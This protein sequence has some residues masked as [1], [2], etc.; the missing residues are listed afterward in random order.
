MSKP[1]SGP[2]E[3]LAQSELLGDANIELEFLRVREMETEI[4]QKAN[5]LEEVADSALQNEVMRYEALSF[6]GGLWVSE[7]SS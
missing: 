1:N 3:A 7:N 4:A 2:L 5:T 6:S